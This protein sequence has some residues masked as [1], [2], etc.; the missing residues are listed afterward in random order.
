MMGYCG[1]NIMENIV[2]NTQWYEIEDLVRNDEYILDVRE[3]YE[4]ENGS[5]PNVIN[6]PLGQLR[7]RLNEIPK[8]RKIYVCCQ[9]GLRG[10]I[11]CT[12]L[13]QYGYNTSNIDG[14]Y[15]TYSSIKN[16]EKLIRDQ[17]ES[18]EVIL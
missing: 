4:V 6:I 9:V 16:A 18:I 10:Y 3:E 11:A 15:K 5:I 13:N 8:N 12:I 17:D 7:D 2:E 1:A 14:G